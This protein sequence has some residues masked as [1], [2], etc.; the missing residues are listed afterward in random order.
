[1]KQDSNGWNQ[2]PTL[3]V[4]WGEV[5][6]KHTILKLKS[7]KISDIDKLNNI[8]IELNQITQVIGDMGRFPVGL[9][10]LVD[11]LFDVNSR[12]WEIEE[13]KRAAERQGLFG[14]DF[15]KLA[16]LVY[17]ENDRRA[18]IKRQINVLL[19]SGIVEEKSYKN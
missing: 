17:K 16:R 8:Y 14:E 9:G 13:G 5:F 7:L 4:S 2:T 15:I 10:G 11:A 1:M 3:P 19:R 18:A 6:D 12:L